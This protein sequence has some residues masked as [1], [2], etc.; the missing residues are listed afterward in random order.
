M[1][2]RGPQQPAGA[3]GGAPTAA[4]LAG[5]WVGDELQLATARAQ[6]LERELEHVRA[7][8]AAQQEEVARLQEVLATV[9]GRTRRHEAGQDLAR[10]VKQELATLQE[11]LAAEAS[12]RREL[13]ARL[14]R[15]TERDHGDEERLQ[16]ALE[17]VVR[18]LDRFEGRQS[19]VDDRQRHLELGIAERDQGGQAADGRLDALERRVDSDREA[20]HH[21]ADAISRLDAALP[22]LVTGIDELRQRL[23]AVQNDQR[24]LD[25]DIAS[26]RAV[27]D[28]EGDLLEVLEQ[29]RATRARTEE[30]LNAVEEQI[31]Q[32]RRTVA[33]SGD[34]RALLARS[35]SG[36]Q[37]Q[38]RGLSEELEALRLLFVAHFRRQLQAD[39]Q[40]GRRRIEEVEREARIARDL[41]VRLS[42]QSD[43]L[44]GG[45]PL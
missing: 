16:R 26:L 25:D 29:Q 18:R 23:Q 7:A 4:D 11:Q 19:A 14:E 12:V 39:E 37:G 38:L 3:A 9:D 36:V 27:R 1:T 44:R 6:A 31:E 24:R 35:Q 30:R 15:T 8:L 10:E 32:V 41:L 5:S 40:A 17:L 42:E 28:R 43:E 34:E 22:G 33:D 2:T 45:Q 13:A 20:V 21:A